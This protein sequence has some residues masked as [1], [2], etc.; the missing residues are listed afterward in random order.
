MQAVHS[1]PVGRSLSVCTHSTGGGGGG[2]EGG[3]VT[4]VTF[5]QILSAMELPAWSRTLVEAQIPASWIRN[6]C[7]Q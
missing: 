4:I 7:P 1:A 6:I 5:E 2:E 3:E